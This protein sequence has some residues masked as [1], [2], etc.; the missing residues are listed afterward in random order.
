MRR[1][2][3]GAYERTQR[4]VVY[5]RKECVRKQKNVSSVLL[6][7]GH[8][9]GEKKAVRFTRVEARKC[10]FDSFSIVQVKIKAVRWVGY[11]GVVNRLANRMELL[12]QTIDKKLYKV[13]LEYVDV[14]MFEVRPHGPYRVRVDVDCM[15]R[16][17]LAH[18][19]AKKC[20]VTDTRLQEH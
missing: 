18:Q 12:H 9:K 14:Q 15:N 5:T 2:C 17:W 20:P 1:S 13:V 4:A 16:G 10:S 7:L 11:Y 8:R 6:E 3:V 19:P